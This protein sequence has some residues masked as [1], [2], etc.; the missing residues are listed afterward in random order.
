MAVVSGT[1]GSVVYGGTAGTIVAKIME[2]TGMIIIPDPG[3]MGQRLT[4][5]S[6]KEMTREQAL[7]LIFA[8][9]QKKNFE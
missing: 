1:A 6:P 4:I 3:V 9:L 2:W 8:A 5:F 7:S